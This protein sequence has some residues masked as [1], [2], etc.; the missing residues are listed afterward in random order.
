VTGFGVAVETRPNG[1]VLALTGEL[2]MGSASTLEEA[3]ERAEAE[4]EPGGP[5]VVD[6]RHLAFIDS[7]GLR[8]LLRAHL[9]AATSGR[10]LT[11]VRG[12]IEVHRVFTIALPDGRLSFVDAPE[13]AWA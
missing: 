5:L 3:L 6:L 11:L 2:D 7:S 13:D 12:P 1:T 9:R 4:A 10:R 8:V